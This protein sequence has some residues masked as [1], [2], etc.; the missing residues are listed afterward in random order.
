MGKLLTFPILDVSLGERAS[1]A[2]VIDAIT[3]DLRMTWVDVRASIIAVAAAK[4][5]RIAVPSAECAFCAELPAE[6]A[7]D[8]GVQQ[9]NSLANRIRKDW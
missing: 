9:L 1:D 2:I 4:E 5:L 8:V 7:E 3:D 6:T